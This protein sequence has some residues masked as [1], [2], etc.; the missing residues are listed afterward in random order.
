M[1]QS[2]LL[3]LNGDDLQT[4]IVDAIRSEFA[5]QQPAPLVS[6]DDEML[7][8]KQ[9]AELLQTT[10]QSVIRWTQQGRLKPYRI[11]GRAVRYKKSDVLSERKVRVP[12]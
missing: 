6:Q 2:V 5:N 8:Q 11:G 3:Q 4:M 9:V 10:K 7:T 12:R 1:N